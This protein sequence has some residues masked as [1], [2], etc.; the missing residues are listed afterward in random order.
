[1][2]LRFYLAVEY[3]IVTR[4]V[5][6]GVNPIMR[7]LFRMPIMFYRIGLGGMIGKQV[8][9]LT[10]TGRKTGKPRVTALGYGYDAG[11]DTY[12]VMTGWGGK[13][14]WLCN[15]LKNPRIHVRV[16]AREFDGVAELV[17]EEEGIAMMRQVARINPLAPQMWSRLSGIPFDGSD[18]S[19]RKLVAYF[20]SLRL[21][22]Q[23]HE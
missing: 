14:D 11:S 16:G 3:F 20:P 8:L 7:V 5:R 22:A 23:E 1:M 4:F 17:S 2:F 19:L 9:L 10:T 13:T 18:E 21:R 6:N 12:H 15:V